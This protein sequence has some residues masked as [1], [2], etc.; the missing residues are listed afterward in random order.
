M[1]KVETLQTQQNCQPTGPLSAGPALRSDRGLLTIGL[2]VL[3]TALHAH[4][5][6]VEN[7]S[8]QQ[9]PDQLQ[10]GAAL[11]AEKV[12]SESRWRN[13]HYG[14]RH[15]ATVSSRAG[16][17]E[18]NFLCI[19]DISCGWVLNLKDETHCNTERAG[20]TLRVRVASDRLV[21]DFQ[22]RCSGY[23]LV[24]LGTD[25]GENHLLTEMIETSDTLQLSSVGNTGMFVTQHYSSQ[26]AKS[27]VS[28]AMVAAGL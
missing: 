8:L 22:S 1:N 6:A 20:E 4:L 24:L 16:A 17:S 12:D 2:L 15:Y 7:R 14:N 18:L 27:A 13:L 19:S 11:P 3:C 9:P 10:L 21:R 28:A 5:S 26:G 23:G 25:P